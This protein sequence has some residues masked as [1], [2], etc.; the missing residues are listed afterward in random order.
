M[1]D[2]L[3]EG[4]EVEF[5]IMDGDTSTHVEGTIYERTGRYL[6]VNVHTPSNHPDVDLVGSPEFAPTFIVY[7]QFKWTILG[8]APKMSIVED[9]FEIVIRAK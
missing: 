9:G 8:I 6:R 5:P 2:D 4:T 3:T 7:R 1:I